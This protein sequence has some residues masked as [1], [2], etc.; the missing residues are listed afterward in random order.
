MGEVEEL[1]MRIKQLSPE[2]T[3]KLRGW[4]LELDNERWDEQIASDAKSG[5]FKNLIERARNEFARGETSEL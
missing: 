3:A 4:F 5:R 2:D 1:E